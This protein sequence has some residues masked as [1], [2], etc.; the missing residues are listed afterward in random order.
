MPVADHRVREAAGPCQLG[1]VD[2]FEAHDCTAPPSTLMACPVTAALLDAEPDRVGHL[3][4]RDEPA[5]RLLAFQDRPG[6]ARRCGRSRPRW[7]RRVAVG[8]RGVDVAGADRVDGDA[9][10]G[11]FGGGRADQAEHAVLARGVGGDVGLADQRRDDATT[12]I[13]PQPASRMAG[14]ARRMQRNGAVRLSSSMR[15]QSASVVRSSRAEWPAP[16]VGD[17]DL[18]RAPALLDRRRTAASTAAGSVTSAGSTSVGPGTAGGR[19]GQFGLAAGGQRDAQARRAQPLRDA[20]P[21]PRR[22]RSPRPPLH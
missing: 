16:G 9:G 4:R 1:R 8:H 14:T 7:R 2:P 19:L 21:M 5:D 13:R 22:R 11:Q 18:D 12:T 15:C 6:L 3:V 20:R 17:Q 10:R